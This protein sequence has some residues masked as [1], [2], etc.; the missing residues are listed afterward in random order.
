MQTITVKYVNFFGE[1]VEEKLHFHLSKGELMNMELQRTPLSAKIAA[2][3]GGEASAIDAYKLLCEFVGAAYG[4]RS[5]DG[6]RFFKDKRSTNAFLASPAFDALLD[7]LS[8]DPK[9]SNKFLAGLFPDDIM[10]KAK[11]LIEENPDASLEEL[12]K[13]AEAN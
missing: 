6:K 2:M 4:E 7:K 12:R 9:F 5:E 8:A 13:M 10:G 3:N 1:E 11:K